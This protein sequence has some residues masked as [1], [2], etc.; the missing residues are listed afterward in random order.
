MIAGDAATIARGLNVVPHLGA[1]LLGL[2][3]VIVG[4]VLARLYTADSALE[5]W[6]KNCRFGIRPDNTWSN[7]Y[8][9]SMDNL[10]PILFPISFDAYRLT[11]MHPYQGQVTSTYLMLNLPGENILLTDAMLHFTGQE[12]W[13]DTLGYY[14][15]QIRKVEWTGKD[16][17][18]HSGTRIPVPA[19]ITPYRRVYH[20]DGVRDLR[21][22][23]GELI[24]SPSEGLTLPA[25][26]I[27]E[28]A[29]I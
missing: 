24:Y 18:R 7:S 29:W 25:L 6:V 21:R 28:R 12:V 5:K 1:K 15:D 11:E 14:A 27:T 19:G 22:I 4:G 20:E 16:F 10:Y 23:E 9:L 2:T 3:V 26:K 13:G 8:I 17:A